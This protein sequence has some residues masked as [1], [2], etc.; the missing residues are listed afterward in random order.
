M[1]HPLARLHVMTMGWAVTVLIVAFLFGARGAADF[2]P[3]T[4]GK[5]GELELLPRQPAGR[6]ERLLLIPQRMIES[7]ASRLFH[8]GSSGLTLEPG[9]GLDLESPATRG[10]QQGHAFSLGRFIHL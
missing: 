2:T 6:R 8:A 5:K 3:Q 1:C 9:V 10:R 4:K 7:P